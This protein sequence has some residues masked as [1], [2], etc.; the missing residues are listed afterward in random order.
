[1]GLMIGVGSTK[2]TFP[3]DYYYG[4]EWDIT[5]SN[6]KPTRIGKMELHKELHLERRWKRCIL[7]ARKRFYK[8][9]QRRGGRPYRRIRHDGNGIAGHVR[10]F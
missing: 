9:R 2:P 1:M 7:L 6:P 8:A 3:Y 5:V 10:S 4:I